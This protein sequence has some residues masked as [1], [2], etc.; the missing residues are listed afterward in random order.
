M[1][2]HTVDQPIPTKFQSAL[3]KTSHKKHQ[4]EDTD[5]ERENK[6]KKE[7][8]Q[9]QQ[10][11]KTREKEVKEAT[12]QKQTNIHTHTLQECKRGIK[13]NREIPWHYQ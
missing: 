13:R 5:S 4:R 6:K 8:T 9:Q 2:L 10:K 12:K 7:H 1:L 3:R 11:I